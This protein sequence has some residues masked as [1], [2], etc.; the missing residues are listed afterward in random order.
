MVRAGVRREHGVRVWGKRV[1]G[2]VRG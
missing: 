2:V 1:L